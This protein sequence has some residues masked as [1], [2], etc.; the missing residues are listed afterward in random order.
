M[1]ILTIYHCELLALALDGIARIKILDKLEEMRRIIQSPQTYEQVMNFALL[2]ADSKVK[3]L[4][5]KIELDRPKVSYSEA[6]AGS[7]TSVLVEDF[8]K[9]ISSDIVIGRNKAFRWMRDN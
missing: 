1:F 7:Q 4:Q 9:T 6:V 8:V 3:D 2:L 5:K